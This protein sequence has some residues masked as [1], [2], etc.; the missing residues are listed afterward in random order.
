MGLSAALA[1][2]T[3]IGLAQQR[4]AKSHRI[5]A[6][7]RGVKGFRRFRNSQDGTWFTRS[8]LGARFRQGLGGSV[9]LIIK[10]NDLVQCWDLSA[11]GRPKARWA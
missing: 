8:V 4:Y 11:I 1:N 10:L 9:V 5:L 3:E 2:Q 6:N 7:C